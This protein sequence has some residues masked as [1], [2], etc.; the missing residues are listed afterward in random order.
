MW[1]NFSVTHEYTNRMVERLDMRGEVT[2]FLGLQNG[3]IVTLG[4][5]LDAWRYELLAATFATVGLSND[6][7]NSVASFN[8]A[9]KSGEAKFLSPKEYES[10]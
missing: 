5:D 4:N 9:S 2:E 8:Q 1:N 3:N 7:R 10:L 6:G